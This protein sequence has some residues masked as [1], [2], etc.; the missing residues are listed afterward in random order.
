MEWLLMLWI[1]WA[2]GVIDEN[3]A[4]WLVLVIIVLGGSA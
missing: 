1:V 4:F 3:V 2:L